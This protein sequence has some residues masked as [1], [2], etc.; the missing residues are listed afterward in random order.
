MRRR[1]LKVLC[2]ISYGHDRSKWAYA[3]FA[4]LEKLEIGICIF[5]LFKEL[6]LGGA[7]IGANRGI[8]SLPARCPRTV[9]P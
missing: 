4:S 3:V 8:H 6:V 7:R 5:P 2:L 1:G 9:F